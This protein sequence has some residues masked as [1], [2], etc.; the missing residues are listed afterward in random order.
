[1]TTPGKKSRKSKK[2]P[3]VRPVSKTTKAYLFRLV[4]LNGVPITTNFKYVCGVTW[5][6]CREYTATRLGADATAVVL[7]LV[8]PRTAPPELILMVPDT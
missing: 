4:S 5:F 3:E 7:E 6:R 2:Q 1:M 8:D